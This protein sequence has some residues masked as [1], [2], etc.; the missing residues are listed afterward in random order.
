MS[1]AEPPI[2]FE[3]Q[4]DKTNRSCGAACLSMVYRSFGEGLRQ[5][6]PQAEIWSAISKPNRSGSLASTTYLMTQ[7]ALKR[8]FCAV[9]FQARHPTQVLRLSRAGAAL[10]KIRVILNHRLQADSASGHYS[11]LADLDPQ[12]VFLHDPVLGPSHRL[13]HAELLDLWL[14]RFDNSE[15]VGNVL[16]AIAADPSAAFAC[17][18]CRT[19]MPAAVDC[20]RCGT[21]VRLQPN[22]LLGCFRD[23]C[24]ARMWNSICCPNCD[25]LWSADQAG[26]ATSEAPGAIPPSSQPPSDKPEADYAKVFAAL[27]Q[28]ASLVMSIPGAANHKELKSHIDVILSARQ[29]IPQA[30]AEESAQIK[31]RDDRVA[32][33]VKAAKQREEAQRQQMEELEKVPPPLDGGELGRALLKHLGFKF[34]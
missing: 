8:G 21:A 11:V 4:T 16:I 27:E 3:A 29:R 18:F 7:D 9:A 6:V 2:P 23:G 13:T 14:P 12:Q 25:L 31:A 32:A 30:L 1:T 17:E 34:S 22:E 26:A 20:P 5:E 28:F 10:G 19:P 24:I 33:I 15:I